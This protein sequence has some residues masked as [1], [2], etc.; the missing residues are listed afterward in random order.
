MEQIWK[1]DLGDGHY[2]NPILY[3]DYSDPDMIRVG[4]DYYMV[5]SSFTYLPGVPLLHSKDMVNWEL[6]NYCVKRLPFKRY[7]QPAHG[8]GTWAPAIRFH[9]EIFYVF[10][11]LPDEGIFVAEATDPYGEWSL[12]CIKEAKGWIDPCPFWDEDG[13]AYMVFAY[14]NSRCGVKHR[15]S[16]CEM[17][18]RA[19]KICSEPVQIYDGF[20]ENPTIE[21]PKLYKRNDYYYIFAPAG[22]VAAGWQ[23]V[24]RS[25]NIYGPYEYKIVMHQGNSQVNGP[26]QGGFVE[27]PDG[28]NFFIHFQDA[29]AF[30]RIVHLQPMCWNGDWPFIGLEMNGDGIGEPVN[31]WKIPV[32]CRKGINDRIPTDDN[33][34]GEK[35]GLQWQWQANPNPLWYSLNKNPGHL[36]LYTINNSCREENL[37]WYAP[38]LCTQLLQA[39]EF[40]A[41]AYL[42]FTGDQNG[43]MAGIGILGH[44]YTY[45]CLAWESNKPC[46]QIWSGEVTDKEGIGEAEEILKLSLPV[47][48]VHIYFK[49]KVSSDAAYNYEY[50]FDGSVYQKAG[51]KYQAVKGSWT[52]A[53]LFLYA[54]NKENKKSTGYGDFEYIGFQKL[55]G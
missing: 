54:R 38:N 15:L 18:Q 43:D 2:K 49:V 16:I 46:I 4:E 19:E 27:L 7:D 42:S 50:S 40:E 34:I 29:K 8:A 55:G 48:T 39:P 44:K 23:T 21:G 5:S 24:L 31:I 14:A 28:S 3:A 47:D 25:K 12:H 30:G 51:L 11:P 26:H 10:I 37:I 35:L 20:L 33:F 52:G 13:K 6:I 45:F 9:N 36:R 53:K 1:S 22:G 41:A 17:D 32:E